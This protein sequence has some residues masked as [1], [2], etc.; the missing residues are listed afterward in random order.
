MLAPHK[1]FA[2]KTHLFELQRFAKQGSSHL[3]EFSVAH[4]GPRFAH[5]FTA[6]LCTK[7]VQKVPENYLLVISST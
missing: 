2:A 4:T 7:C 1:S 6:Y 3:W 5:G